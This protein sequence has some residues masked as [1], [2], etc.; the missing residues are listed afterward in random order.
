MTRNPNMALDRLPTNWATVS[1]GTPTSGPTARVRIGRSS[2]APPKPTEPDTAAA[3]TLP[4]KRAS[5][6]SGDDG[7]G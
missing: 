5:R 6:M 4:T 3:T 7:I 2:S 1:K